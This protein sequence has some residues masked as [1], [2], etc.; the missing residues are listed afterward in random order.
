[1]TF[2]ATIKFGW[3]SLQL[4]LLV[5]AQVPYGCL[6]SR[7][8]LTNYGKIIVFNPAEGRKYQIPANDGVTLKRSW[9]DARRH[10]ISLGGDLVS[11]SNEKENEA[12]KEFISAKGYIEFIWIGGKRNVSGGKIFFLC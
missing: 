7:S 2:Q 8:N 1:M 4:Q 12:V 5:R 11:I 3:I 9:P 6:P 10:C